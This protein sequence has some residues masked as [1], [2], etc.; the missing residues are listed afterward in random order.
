MGQFNLIPDFLGD[1]GGVLSSNLH[2][3]EAPARERGPSTI[4]LQG[5][6]WPES[7][8]YSSGLANSNPVAWI[9]CCLRNDSMVDIRAG[10]VVGDV[11]PVFHGMAGL[12]DC[13]PTSGGKDTG[14]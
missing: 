14:G 1:S 6:G 4:E 8:S 11:Y 13:V 7:G 2:I 12:V 10:K 3:T 9:D 5:G